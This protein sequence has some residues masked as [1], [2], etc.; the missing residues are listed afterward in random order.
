MKRIFL[1]FVMCIFSFTYAQED[2][3]T[4][5]YRNVPQEEMEVFMDNEAMYWSK[6]HAKLLKKGKITGWSMMTRVRGLASEPNVY[7][8]IGIGSYDNLDHGYDDW[9]QAVK[10][11]RSSID[12]EKLKIIDERLKQKKYRVGGALLNRVSTAGSSTDEWNYLVH[13]YANASDV[14]AFLDLQ[15][16]YLKPFFD[17][18]MKE[19]NT[20]QVFWSTATVLSPRG[21]GYNWNCYTVDAYKNYSDIFNGWNKEVSYP[22][23][24]MIE[25]GKL[26]KDQS[27]YKS[28]VWKRA[29]W[30]DADGNLKQ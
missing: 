14:S 20:K 19:K 8:Y 13:N 21:H 22:E 30:L 28:V 1:F 6:I 16:K 29:M 18:N 10:E 7:F 17:K 11:V 4:Y 24:G 27:F 15:E 5:D 3:F 12:K 26:M 23:E 2:L 25:L 9:G